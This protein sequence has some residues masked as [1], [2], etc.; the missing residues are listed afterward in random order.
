MAFGISIAMQAPTI[1][2]QIAAYRDPQ[3]IPTLIDLVDRASRPENLRVVVCWQHAPQ[4]VTAQFI[5]HGFRNW[6]V[7]R[8]GEDTVHTLRYGDARIELIDV[9]HMRSQGAC[10]ARNK[11][12]Q[13]YQGE[14]YTLQLD[15]HHRFVPNWD[16]KV[17]EMLESLRPSSPKP[18]LTAYLPAY[19]PDD[20]TPETRGRTPTGTWFR[21]ITAGGVV[22]FNSGDIT[23]WE[24]MDAPLPGRFYSAHFAFADGSFAQEVQHDPEYFFYG[25]EISIAVRAFTHGYDIYYPHRLIAWH[26]YSRKGRV[27][28][29]DEHGSEAKDTGSV[30]MEWWERD[31]RCLQRNRILFGIDGEDPSQIDFGK[32][33]FGTKRSLRQYEAYAGVS[34]KWRGVEQATL[35]RLPPTMRDMPDDETWKA[36]LKRSNSIRICSHQNPLGELIAIDQCV[37]EVE[38]RAGQVMHRQI[39]DGAELRDRI[40]NHWLDYVLHFVSDD[41]ERAPMRYVIMTRNATSQLMARIEEPLGKH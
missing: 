40:E 37:V 30:D 20:D 1:F 29:W 38:D 25:E 19:E 3:L 11:I 18:L 8:E 35:Q 6:T 31:R 41:V 32:Y 24:A 22:I 28:M 2:V 17:I 13:H 36:S 27:K 33:G 34:F 21:E 23:G 26:E 9:P 7:N 16:V 39:F 5:A 15:S 12:Q 14:R 10:W 4:E